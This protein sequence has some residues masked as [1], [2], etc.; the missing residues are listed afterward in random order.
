MEWCN[1]GMPGVFNGFY[2]F[3]NP[4]KFDQDLGFGDR[5]PQILGIGELQI[6]TLDEIPLCS[7]WILPQFM[8]AAQSV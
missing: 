4:L 1:G 8:V 6:G 2:H 3:W 7:N 5:I